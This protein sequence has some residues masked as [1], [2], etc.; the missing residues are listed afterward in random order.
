MESDNIPATVLA[1]MS[2]EARMQEWLDT[3]DDL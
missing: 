1:R 3:D 2:E